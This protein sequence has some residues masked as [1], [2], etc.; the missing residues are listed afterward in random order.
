VEILKQIDGKGQSGG[1]LNSREEAAAAVYKELYREGVQILTPVLNEEREAQ[2][3]TRLLLEYVCGTNLQTLILD[4]ERPVSAQEAAL[5]R[6]YVARR[7]NREPLAYILGE[8]DFMGLSFEVSPDVL[9]PEQDTENLVE[10]ILKEGRDGER[11]LDLCTGSG[12][13]LLSL[14]HYSN[15]SVG[16]G[17]D[18]SQKALDTACRN[19][20]SLGLS[21]RAQWRQ[22]DLF[23]A[24]E[25]DEKFDLIVSN[26][27]YIAS[28]VI[29]SLAAEVKCHEPRLSLDGGE[30]GLDFYRRIIPGAVA[31]LVIGGMLYMEIGFDQ[32]E[33]VAGLMRKAGYYEVAV[34]KD[35]GGNDRIVRGIRSIHQDALA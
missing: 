6:E 30:D 26:P 25:K 17:T 21:D 3:D 34:L 7:K 24:L 14:L 16:I 35:Y 11:I 15:S 28:G 8:W 2:L 27:P 29:P 32:G 19:A 10:E 31:H 5:F 13:I 20:D 22:G 4:G 33:A 18:L 23:D 1:S 12:C 9:I